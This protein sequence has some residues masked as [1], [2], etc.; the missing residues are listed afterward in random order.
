MT[1]Q[2]VKLEVGEVAGDSRVKEEPMDTNQ[3]DKEN[4][5]K[6][7]RAKPVLSKQN[8]KLIHCHSNPSFTLQEISLKLFLS[9]KRQL[10][11][12]P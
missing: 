12:K 1:G 9:C 8:K 2:K 3:G 10:K 11:F 5:E 4:R 6:K 7:V